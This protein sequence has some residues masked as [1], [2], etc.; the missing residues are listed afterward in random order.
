MGYSIDK[1]KQDVLDELIDLA[2]AGIT[3]FARPFSEFLLT[4]A[5]DMGIVLTQDQIENMT[6]ELK[7]KT[8]EYY[9]KVERG[10]ATIRTDRANPGGSAYWQRTAANA[11]SLAEHNHSVQQLRGQIE[12][13]SSEVDSANRDRDHYRSSPVGVMS[14]IPVNLGNLNH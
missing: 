5:E 3:T 2:D 7:E 9:D 1:L 14:K 12:D 8:K 13:L 11:K 10:A 4:K 6:K